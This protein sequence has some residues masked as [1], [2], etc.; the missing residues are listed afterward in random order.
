MN[1]KAAF[2]EGSVLRHVVVMICTSATSLLS[3]FLVDIFT[4]VY[5]GILQD[6]SL[7]AALALSK[8]LLFFITSMVLGIAVGA[9]T[10]I[11]KNAGAGA[12]ERSK[13]FASTGFVL[14]TAVTVAAAALELLCLD[15]AIRLLGAHGGTFLSA[16]S[17]LRI[18]LPATLL[19]AIGQMCAQ[20]LRTA[21]YGRQAMWI[22]LIATAAVAVADPLLIF[23]F[24]LGLDGAGYAYVVS[25]AMSAGLGLYYVLLVT[26]L[27]SKI[28]AEHFAADVAR[29]ARTA[30]P[31][32]VGNLATPVGLAYLMASMAQFGARALAG[33]AVVDRI[34]QFAFCV[35]F[36]LPGAL[37]PVIAQ[38]LGAMRRD[39][40]EDAIKASSSM[41]V[42]YGAVVSIALALATNLLCDVFHMEGE[43][44]AIVFA[45][46]RFGGVLWTLIGLQFIA[47]S[48]FITMHRAIYVT[49][50]G[51]LRATLGTIPFV[52]YGARA[53]GGEGAVIGQLVGSA[54]VALAA[55]VLSMLVMRSALREIRSERELGALPDRIG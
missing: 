51:W 39:R 37:S 9:S 2:T 49:V 11:A 18:T 22:L 32:V 3:I 38:N 35:V 24:R 45:F 53:F 48:I 16:R 42:A 6:N 41:V 54:L 44:R 13:Q 28:D 33:V 14:V 47:I 20:V 43:G 40:V 21:G 25:C 15:P 36:V 1:N 7:L 5:I 4:V 30:F 8:T 26:G 29:I 46:G 12:H 50:F 31:A 52:W 19:M 23:G 17:Y 34:T 27:T 55:F 10:V